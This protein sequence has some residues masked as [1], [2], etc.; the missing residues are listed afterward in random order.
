MTFIHIFYRLANRMTSPSFQFQLTSSSR[1]QRVTCWIERVRLSGLISP[2][3]GAIHF[4]YGGP[5]CETWSVSRWRFYDTGEGPAP[6][7]S[8]DDI[9]DE[10][11]GWRTLRLRDIQQIL[12][13][14]ALLLFMLT[15]FVTQLISGG[16]AL[17]EHPA[18]PGYRQGRQPPSVWLLPIVQFLLKCRQVRMIHISQ[19]YWQALSPE[20]NNVLGYNTTGGRTTIFGVAQQAQSHEC[21][22]QSQLRWDIAKGYLSYGKI[23]TLSRTSMCW[24]C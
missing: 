7:R 23:E 20:A 6:L 1:L 15:I 18:R 10:I 14:N 13:S 11:W 21:A 3:R 4:V 8:G 9:Y 16:G 24:S 17:M 19:G 5:P 22:Y 2:N 12:C